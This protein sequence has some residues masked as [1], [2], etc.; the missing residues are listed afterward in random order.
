MTR[1]EVAAS[2]LRLDLVINVGFEA[3]MSRLL[4]IL[5][6]V[7]AETRLCFSMV[8]THRLSIV[9]YFMF[10]ANVDARIRPSMV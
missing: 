9:E 1:H 2:E 7:C 4:K 8:H 6:L 10:D 5:G 3:E